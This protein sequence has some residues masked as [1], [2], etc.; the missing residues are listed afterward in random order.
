[1]VAWELFG[2]AFFGWTTQQMLQPAIGWTTPGTVLLVLALFAVWVVASYRILRMGVYVSDHGV[3][4]VGLL[5][6]RTVPWSEV[7][8]ITVRETRHS[9]GRLQVAGGMSVHL[10]P[11]EGAPI[12]TTLW[13]QGIDFAFRRHAFHAAYQELRQHLNAYRQHTRNIA[14][15]PRNI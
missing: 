13:A 15:G 10:D 9:V 11:R 14:A 12:E 3:R 4:V 7:E 1:M 5:G 8:R 2:L 6:S